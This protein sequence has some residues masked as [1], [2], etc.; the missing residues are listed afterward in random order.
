MKLT[1]KNPSFFYLYIPSWYVISNQLSPE[2]I[3]LKNIFSLDI[4]TV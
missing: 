3:Y 4:L 2:D 1:E